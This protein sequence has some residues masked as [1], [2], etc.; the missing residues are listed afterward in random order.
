MK[1][2]DRPTPKLHGD[3]AMRVIALILAS[4]FVAIGAV[5]IV[6]AMITDLVINEI[7]NAMRRFKEWLK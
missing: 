4:P 6:L 1:T 2:Q 7:D 5:W 3:G